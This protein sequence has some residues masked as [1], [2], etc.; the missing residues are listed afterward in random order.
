MADRGDLI[1]GRRAFSFS[2]SS[3]SSC[4]PLRAACSSAACCSCAAACSASRCSNRRRSAAVLRGNVAG[5]S[6]E[7]D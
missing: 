6:R 2:C 4:N 5:S 7:A 3:V 1:R